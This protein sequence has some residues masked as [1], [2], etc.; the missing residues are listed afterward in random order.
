[1]TGAA[2]PQP[3]TARDVRSYAWLPPAEGA[4]PG[5]ADLAFLEQRTDG[6]PQLT[7][8]TLAPPG[9]PSQLARLDTPPTGAAPGLLAAGSSG[10]LAYA[11]FHGNVATALRVC[12]TVA[13]AC[14][15]SPLPPDSVLTTL[16][17]AA[18]GSTLLL[19]AAATGL[20]RFDPAT[21]T[22]TPV[23]TDT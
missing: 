18:D 11:L 7:R 15:T 2:G 17:W 13:A 4:S 23:L 21:G 22:Q 19:H 9:G 20:L 6:A 5:V 12:P 16:A 14:T 10:H 1:P 8:L 3:L